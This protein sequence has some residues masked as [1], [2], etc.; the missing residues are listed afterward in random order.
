MTHEFDK[1]SI[2]DLDLQAVIDEDLALEELPDGNALASWATAGSASTASCPATSAST[3]GS[4]S[5]YG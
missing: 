3:V 4:A 2:D 1:K 5:T